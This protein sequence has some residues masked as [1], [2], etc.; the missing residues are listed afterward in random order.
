VIEQEKRFLDALE[1][2]RIYRLRGE[3]LELLDEASLVLLRFGPSAG[4]SS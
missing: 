3:T 1:N 4:S 2:V